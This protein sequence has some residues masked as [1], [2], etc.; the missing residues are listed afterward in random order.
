[1]PYHVVTDFI[2]ILLNEELR[3][4]LG[5]TQSKNSF[6]VEVIFLKDPSLVHVSFDQ[7]NY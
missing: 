1:M 4:L 7:R 2:I 3:T 5:S 6:Y